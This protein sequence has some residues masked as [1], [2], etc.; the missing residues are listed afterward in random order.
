MTGFGSLGLVC[1]LGCWTSLL[2]AIFIWFPAALEPTGYFNEE[3][4]LDL[5]RLHGLKLELDLPRLHG[6]I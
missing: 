5:T 4:K 6:H 2:M 1:G 3:L